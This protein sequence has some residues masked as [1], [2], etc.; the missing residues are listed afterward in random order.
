MILCWITLFVCVFLNPSLFLFSFKV[1]RHFLVQIFCFQLD[2]A[3]KIRSAAQKEMCLEPVTQELI[4][5]GAPP[6]EPKMSLIEV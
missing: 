3:D 1:W 5:N 2:F 6:A 4:Q